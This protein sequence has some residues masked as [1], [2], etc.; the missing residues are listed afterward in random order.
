MA[1]MQKEVLFS[2]ANTA[3]VASF[4]VMTGGVRSERMMGDG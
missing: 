2:G 4:L 3:K 1:H